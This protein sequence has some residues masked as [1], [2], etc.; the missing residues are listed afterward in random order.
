MPPT[1]AKEMVNMFAYY[2]NANREFLANRDVGVTKQLCGGATVSVRDW[3]KANKGK[4]LAKL[5]AA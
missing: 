1:T 2:R 4:L 3:A 5:D